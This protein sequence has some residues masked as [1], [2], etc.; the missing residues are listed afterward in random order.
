MTFTKKTSL[1]FFLLQLNSFYLIL[2]TLPH[3]QSQKCQLFLV[4]LGYT[5]CYAKT[6]AMSLKSQTKP[7]AYVSSV[8]SYL[9]TYTFFTMYCEHLILKKWNKPNAYVSS[10]RSYLSTYT[11]FTMYCEHLILKKWNIQCQYLFVSDW[12]VQKVESL[13]FSCQKLIWT[14]ANFQPFNPIE[15]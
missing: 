10:V 13:F 15:F 12:F 5:S 4:R 1:F 7:N 8:R 11:F 14:F 2:D 3:S 9:S 6:W